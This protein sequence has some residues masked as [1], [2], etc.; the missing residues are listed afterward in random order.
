MG[1]PQPFEVWLPPIAITLCMLV[2]IISL[3][4]ITQKLW[5]RRLFSQNAIHDRSN[6]FPEF[7]WL[8]YDDK[9]LIY[10][11]NLFGN[12]PWGLIQLA[13]PALISMA[14]CPMTIF[15]YMPMVKMFWPPEYFDAIPDINNVIRG[16]L[17]PSGLV[18]AIAFGFA[19]QVISM[20]LKNHYFS[21]N[22]G[23]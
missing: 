14:F 6:L 11:L 9:V 8:S 23:F 13:W 16:F 19:Y 2:A 12:N 1:G 22:I 20:F 3:S 17:T 7:S 15:L 18:Y 21:T 4:L 10:K 5:W